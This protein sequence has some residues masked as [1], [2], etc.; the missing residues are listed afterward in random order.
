MLPQL[1]P[2]PRVVGRQQLRQRP[3]NL[4]LS[5]AV[6]AAVVIAAAA[7]AVV[8]AAAAAVVVAAVAAAVVEAV[9]AVAFPTSRPSVI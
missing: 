2:P 4:S 5:P 9:A 7:A 8:I 1:P 6:A 3:L